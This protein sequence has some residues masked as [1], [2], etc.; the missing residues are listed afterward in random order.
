MPPEVKRSAGPQC[1]FNIKHTNGD[2]TPPI[3]VDRTMTRENFRKTATRGSDWLQ[4]TEWV[5]LRHP[6]KLDLSRFLIRHQLFVGWT[7]VGEAP[8]QI[9]MRPANL[10]GLPARLTLLYFADPQV[11]PSSIFATKRERQMYS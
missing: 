1:L 2:F 8:R 5:Q 9:L 6:M 3:A 11:S 7:D 4:K 10:V